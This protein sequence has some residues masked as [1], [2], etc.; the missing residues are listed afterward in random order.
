MYLCH[1]KAA[2]AAM[3]T[4]R[5][6]PDYINY[7]N[8][9]DHCGAELDGDDCYEYAEAILCAECIKDALFEELGEDYRIR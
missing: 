6:T 7:G 4:D 9:C 8:I 2:L 3:E 5:L 1:S